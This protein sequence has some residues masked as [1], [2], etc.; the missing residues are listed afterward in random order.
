MTIELQSSQLK[1]YEQMIISA[2]DSI[3]SMGKEAAEISQQ[4]QR[5]E[6]DRGYLRGRVGI[7]I[8]EQRLV[9]G[10][11]V[12][13]ERDSEELREKL[14]RLRVLGRLFDKIN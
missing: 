7:V 10:V 8:E 13:L 5:V 6:G 9:R 3:A 1:T 2:K 4:V 12:L 14:G 11:N